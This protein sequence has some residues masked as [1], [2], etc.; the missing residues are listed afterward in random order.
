[1][2]KQ[3]SRWP[4]LLLLFIT[5]AGKSTLAQQ[6]ASRINIPNVM[7]TDVIYE[8][9]PDALLDADLPF[10]CATT[11][12][13]LCDC[14]RSVA[15]SRTRVQASTLAVRTSLQLLHLPAV[16]VAVTALWSRQYPALS[17]TVGAPRFGWWPLL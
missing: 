9:R 17:A 7:Q 2:V 4:A 10:A 11:S 5:C 15:V 8:V 1:V 3:G 13:L 16:C 12:F 6:L 14:G